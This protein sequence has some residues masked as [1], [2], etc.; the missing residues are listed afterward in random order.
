VGWWQILHASWIR[1][2]LEWACDD[3]PLSVWGL[4]QH[5]MLMSVDLRTTSNMGPFSTLIIFSTREPKYCAEEAS[6]CLR[7]CVCVSLVSLSLCNSQRQYLRIK[8][9]DGINKRRWKVPENILQPAEYGLDFCPK[10]LHRLHIQWSKWHE[11]VPQGL[12]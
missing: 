2:K 10:T 11:I 9:L 12:Q 1:H 6:V 7:V 5:H 3:K 8:F 4:C